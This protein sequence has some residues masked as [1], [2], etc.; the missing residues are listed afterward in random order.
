MSKNRKGFFQHFISSINL[1]W[2]FLVTFVASILFLSIVESSVYYYLDIQYLKQSLNEKIT[3]VAGMIG[4]N[5]TSS[6]QFNSRTDALEVLSSLNNEPMIE[7]AYLFTADGLLLA[8]YI[9]DNGVL[10]VPIVDIKKSVSKQQ[11][12]NLIVNKPIVLDGEII[13][14]IYLSAKLTE[15]VRRRSTLIFLAALNITFVG[16]AALGVAVV[17]EK[18]FVRPI[19]ELANLSRDVALQKNY[20]LRA[21]K[22]SDDEIGKLV[23]NFNTMLGLIQARDRQVREQTK[24]LATSNEELEQFAYIVSHDLKSPLVTI[25][26]YASRLPKQIASGDAA[27]IDK[28][29]DRI[30]YS[31]NRM[32][33][34]IDDVLSFSRV[35]R[36]GNERKLVDLNRAVAD[37]KKDLQQ[38]IENKQVRLEIDELP[39]VYANENEVRQVFQNLVENAIKYG[40][41]EPGM[42]VH[43]GNNSTEDELQIYVQDEGPGIAPEYHKKVFQLFQRV[44]QEQKGSGLGLAI[45]AKAMNGLSAR[46][47][48]ES[49][50]GKGSTFW[51]AFPNPQD[52]PPD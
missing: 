21:K 15:I 22:R 31:V 17:S 6:L 33:H 41:P 20:S 25:S 24:Q 14:S 49:D 40:C 1:K 7:E 35:G 11:G 13:G 30:Q 5:S 45:V 10:S 42:R 26:G 39:N 34:L 19:L 36:A 32:G 51:L 12:N 52:L 18:T 47:W 4:D 43:V 16:L 46:F 27:Q 38:T 23:D 44:D 29:I 37:I 50:L 28:C 48:L 3:I 9:A 2:K 8:E